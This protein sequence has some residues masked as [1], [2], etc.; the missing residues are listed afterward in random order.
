[1]GHLV[2]Q[3]HIAQLIVPGLERDKC[4][5]KRHAVMQDD[6][7]Q[8]KCEARVYGLLV[9]QSETHWASL[10]SLG[11]NLLNPGL[12]MSRFLALSSDAVG[13]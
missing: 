2:T 13:L 10:N 9:R 1:M 3:H 6:S 11:I 7:S 4:P 8:T 12:Q 5:C